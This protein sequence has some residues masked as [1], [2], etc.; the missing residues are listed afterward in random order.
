VS[1]ATAEYEHEQDSVARFVDDCCLVGGGVHVVVKVAAV[2][3][4]YEQW[5]QGEGV[6]PVKPT[7][8]G[9]TLRARFN[10]GGERTG[11]ARFYTGITLLSDTDS[12]S[13]TGPRFEP[14]EF[15]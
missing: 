5:C 11:S 1:V 13:T 4:A 7:M 6:R 12:E 8:F 15:R 10:V 2:R 14:L 3:E 9:K